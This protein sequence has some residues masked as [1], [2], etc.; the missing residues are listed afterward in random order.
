MM[1]A[2]T[3]R[4]PW[5]WLIVEGDKDI[6]NR[7]WRP[8]DK[9]VGQLIA[10]HAGQRFEG[11]TYRHLVKSGVR[12]PARGLIKCGGIVG[13]ARLVKVVERHDSPWFRGPVGW[14]LD[15]RRPCSFAPCSGSLG[16]WRLSDEIEAMVRSSI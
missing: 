4:Q 1:Y 7:S 15:Q 16:L 3:V 8:A 10:I 6:E 5:A 11:F 13:V 14:V 2:L 12:L 9:H